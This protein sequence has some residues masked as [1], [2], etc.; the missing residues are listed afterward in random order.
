MKVDLFF[1]YFSEIGLDDLAGYQQVK[2]TLIN[3][4]QPA[5]KQKKKKMV[6]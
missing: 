3:I 1:K 6:F 2:I 5:S 4:V